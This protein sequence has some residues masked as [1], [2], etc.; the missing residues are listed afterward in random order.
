MTSHRSR[1]A[2]LG[3]TLLLLPLA[4]SAASSRLSPSF[5]PN[6]GQTD[7]SV[8]FL[9][10]TQLGTFFFTPSEVVLA[11]STPRAAPDAAPL[12]VRFVDA[13]PGSRVASGM[14]L[15]GKVNY[16]LGSDPG[17]WHTGLPTYS[18]ISYAD[19]YP[20]VALAYSADGRPLKGTYTVAPG[21]DPGRIRWRYEGGEARVDEAG[22]LQIRM[23]GGGNGAVALTEEAP[24]AWQEIDGRRVPVSARYVIA[25]DG[26]VGFAIGEYDRGRPLTIDP[27]ITYSTFLGGS[28]FDIA[29]AIAVDPAGNAY[30]A[31]YTASID[32][33]TV[34]PY[35]PSTAGQGD[36]F[37]AKFN[38]DGTPVYSTYL[39]GNYFD[40]ATDVAVDAGG[41]AYV[42]GKTGSADFPTFMAFQPTYA[43]TWDAFVTK[44]NPAGSALVYSTY[45]GGGGEENYINAG[46]TGAIAVDAAGCAYLT[47]NTQS[48]DFPLVNPLQTALRGSVDAFVSKLSADG[49]ALAYSTYLG[50]EGG[51]T[52]WG[53]A[54]DRAGR[55]IVTGDTTSLSFPTA[56]A[57]QPQCAPSFAGCWDVF[58]TKLNA[59]GTN[60][61]YSTYLGGN[62][63]EY[64]D[65]GIGIAVDAAGTA[66][67][68]GMTGSP[69]FPT[70]NPY[71]GLYG[72]Q[73]DAFVA[74]FGSR[75]TLLSS[76]FL[77]GNNSDVGMGIAVRLAKLGPGS[78]GIA[79]GVHVSGLTISEN[80]PVLNPIQATLGGFED[81]F[82][83]KFNADVQGLIYSTYLG[84]TNGREEYGSTGIGVDAA[85]NVYVAGG[86]E[87][88]DYPTLNPYQPSPHGSYDAVLT[89]ISESCVGGGALGIAGSVRTATGQGLRGVTLTLAGPAACANDT[90][91]ETRGDYRFGSLAGGGYT[92]TPVKAGCTFSPPSLELTLTDGSAKAPFTASCR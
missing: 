38:P 5:E 15:S 2:S 65:R 66:Y 7:A 57:F 10:R 55:A 82:V 58:V 53:I 17:A 73:V 78:Q 37:V 12:R 25:A 32:F 29:W 80:F 21:A 92:L 42:T 46:V 71:Q 23:A 44:L 31:G 16:L 1:V 86:S 76:T 63:Q 62:D 59:A 43:G 83:A 33:P 77:G 87:A 84:G 47:G 61:V 56:H 27:V 24:I 22:H 20:G 13:N 35:Q 74:R 67:V 4:A 88:T 60:L 8:R 40:Y 90:E 89:R 34:A 26:S 54:V 19:L 72:G 52:G 85:G 41:N 48:A 64:I 75:G 9:L 11:P 49:S 18:E 51:D 28:I 6:A 79:P 70:R 30:I 50:G 39:G 14:P 45:L 69:N 81:A 36:A 68:T 3:F 91:A